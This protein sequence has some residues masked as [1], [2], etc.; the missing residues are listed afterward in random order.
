VTILIT[1][2]AGFI[3][4]HLVKQFNKNGEN[5]IVILDRD[6]SLVDSD[7]ENKNILI[8]SDVNDFKLVEK[9]IKDNFIDSIIHLAANSDIKTGATNSNA[10]FRDTLNT[11]LILSEIARFYKIKKIFF[12]SS[13]AIFGFRKQRIMNN[14]EFAKLPVSF[15]GIA[16]LASEKIFEQTAKE[17]GVTYQCLRFP[18][19]IGPQL[20]HGLIY[21]LKNKIAANPDILNVLGDGHQS[22]P[23]MHVD[24][25]TSII[26]NVWKSDISMVENISPADNISVREIVEL[27]CKAFQIAP[28][29]N[30]EEKAIGWVGDVPFYS[31]ETSKN[32]I[33]LKTN[34][35]TS[36]QAVND[37]LR[38]IAP[39]S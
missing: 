29:V 23:F 9:T 28:E 37:T 20:T 19:V 21:D 31:Y 18:N 3:G 26:F 7:I 25:L 13:S 5:G 38:E 22:K 33:V 30:Y 16:K 24:D 15:Y 32:S 14:D 17:Y 1:G 35:R 8:K 27:T 12:A 2:G 10:D 11:S 6:I 4:Q 36:I 34:I 39:I